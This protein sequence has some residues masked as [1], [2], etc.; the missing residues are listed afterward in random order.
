MD[1]SRFDTLTKTLAAAGSRRQ[2]LGGLLLASLALLG[3]TPTEETAAHGARPQGKLLTTIAGDIGW[4]VKEETGEFPKAAG[5][6]I[7]D[8]REGASCERYSEERARRTV[9]VS[10]LRQGDCD[11]ASESWQ[12]WEGPA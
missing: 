10:S 6:G 2:A 4:L 3:G 8:A 5:Q 11:I 1:G 12:C 7:F 9:C